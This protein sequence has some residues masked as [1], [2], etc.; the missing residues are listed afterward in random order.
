MHKRTVDHRTLPNLRHKPN[1]LSSHSHAVV[2]YWLVLYSSCFAYVTPNVNIQ[3]HQSLT[4]SIA[5]YCRVAIVR[6]KSTLAAKDGP[7][8]NV[9][10]TDRFLETSKMCVAHILPT[11]AGCVEARPGPPSHAPSK[12][13]R[14][15]WRRFSSSSDVNV[16]NQQRCRKKFRVEAIVAAAGLGGG[17][18]VRC[19]AMWRPYK[20]GSDVQK[21][22]TN[23]YEYYEDKLFKVV[24]ESPE[25]TY[26]LD[27]KIG[28]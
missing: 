20:V 10:T 15:R 9:E 28:Y 14:E 21:I 23:E 18:R 13:G 5:S 19:S 24:Q 27:E 3:F 6:V 8:G 7:L 26:M 22:T 25:R 11:P 17:F 2:C 16:K 12:C 1:K 4:P